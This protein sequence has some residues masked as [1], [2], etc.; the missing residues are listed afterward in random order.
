MQE[1]PRELIV[2]CQQK[3]AAAFEEMYRMSAG[4]VYN[5][6]LRITGNREDAQE[7]AQD[8]FVTVYDKIKGFRFESSFTT[9]L[10]RVTFNTALDHTRKN[11]RMKKESVAF[12][13]KLAQHIESPEGAVEKLDAREREQICHRLLAAVGPTQRACLVMRE[14]EGLSYGEIAGILKININTVRSRLK[15]AREQLLSL[16]KKVGHEGM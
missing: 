9:W 7:A 11:S 5:V 6:A 3:D 16:G 8:V 1:I 10:Y 15:R 4:F 2:R 14:I 13:E 12:D